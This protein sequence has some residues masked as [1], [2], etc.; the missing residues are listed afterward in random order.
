MPVYVKD[1]GVWRTIDR[2]YVRDGTSFTNQTI[3]NVYVKKHLVAF[4]EKM[5]AY[6]KKY[7][8]FKTYNIRF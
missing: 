3:N 5:P 8:I 4:V 1:G 6:Y 7:S 2:V